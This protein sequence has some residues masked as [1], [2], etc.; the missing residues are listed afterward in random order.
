MLSHDGPSRYEEILPSHKVAAPHCELPRLGIVSDAP[1]VNEGYGLTR[2]LGNIFGEYP[3]YKIFTLSPRTSLRVAD[4]HGAASNFICEPIPLVRNRYGSQINKYLNW[5]NYSLLNSID[6]KWDVELD[7]VLICASHLSTLLVGYKQAKIKKV[8]YIVYLMDD[9]RAIEE[10]KWIGSNGRNFMRLLLSGAS[11]WLMISQQLASEYAERLEIEPKPTLIVHNAV[12]AIAFADHP[13]PNQS[14]L[15]IAYAGS[16][17]G[18]HYDALLQISK[19]V[20]ELNLSGL[21]I[22]LTFYTSKENWDRLSI[23]SKCNAIIYGGEIAYR[24]L[25]S[26]LAQHHILLVTSSFAPEFR[27]LSTSSVQTKLTDYMASARAVLSF[28][29]P[30]SACHWFVDRWKCGYTYSE[31]N[32]DKLKSFLSNLCSLHCEIEQFGKQA[33]KAAKNNFTTE[34]VAPRVFNTIRDVAF[35]IR[36]NK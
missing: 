34:L 10:K 30:E 2:T 7:I 5:I 31:F 19:A 13:Y 11:G 32:L 6:T 18:M 21:K 14:T 9:L 16:T 25:H 33:Y 26:T 22:D 24:D 23:D 36:Q 28:G 8:P 17:W 4:L 1:I 12:P 3:A 27:H 20:K 15:S 29:P 35:P